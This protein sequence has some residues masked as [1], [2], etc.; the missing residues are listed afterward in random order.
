MYYIG[1]DVGGTNLVAGLVDGEAR[2]VRKSTMPVDRTRDAQ[3]LMEDMIALTCRLCEEAEIDRKYDVKALGIGIPGQ[4]DN[5]SGTIIKTVNMPLSNTPLRSAFQAVWEAPVFLGNDADCAAIGE[6]WAG[7]ARN[8]DPAVVITLGTGVGGGLVSGGR[9]FDGFSGSG[10]E[11]GHMITHAGG[12]PCTCGGR[13]CWEQ[14]ASATALI[15]QTREAMARCPDSLLWQVAGGDVQRVEG[16]TPFDAAAQGDRTALEVLADYR[17]ELAAGLISLVNMLQPEI[18]C[19]GGGVSNAP[20]ELLLSP[21]RE[22]VRT[23]SYDRA[24]P[25]RIARAALG[26]DAGVIGAALLCRSI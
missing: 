2:L 12:L 11:V 6:Y 20:D 16:K 21:L 13:G 10:M 15:R 23:G 14:Y 26:N 17:Q 1:V 4:V 19:L 9:L 5:R 18:I 3:G 24:H 22:L 7:A 8:C 25:T